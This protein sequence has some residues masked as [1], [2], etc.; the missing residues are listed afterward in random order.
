LSEA[1]AQSI[2]SLPSLF[3]LVGK[4]A[5]VTGGSRGLGREMALALAR[6][7]AKVAISARREQW[8]KPTAEELRT[9]G[10]ECF[11]ATCDVSKETEVAHF[12][13]D[14]MH[15][16]GQID[17]LINNAGISWGA[18]SLEMPPDRWRQVLE[19]NATG[20]FLMSQAVAPH[21]AARGGGKIVNV[22]SI[23]GLRGTPPEV[24]SAAAYSAS[25]GALIALTK[26]L[27]V[28][29]APLNITVN[30][31]APGFFPTRLSEGVIEH[32]QA[33]LL[34]RIP[35]RRFGSEADIHGAI[36]FLASRASDYMTGQVLV[37]DGGSTA[38]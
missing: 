22:S 32:H 19:T 36:V 33:Q 14:V 27:A 34:E 30:A 29:W 11:A 4:V 16:F 20:S 2:D 12:V 25:K 15:R 7:G 6:A 10:H 23:M 38:L 21:L 17:V 24:L 1:A 9:A 3:S 8:L 37:L 28:E 31:L 13:G 26:A 18:P 5:V 35:L